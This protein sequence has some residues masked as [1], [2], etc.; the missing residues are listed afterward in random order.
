MSSTLKIATFNCEN[1]FKRPKVLNLRDYDKARGI[2]NEIE[3]LQALLCKRNYTPQDKRDISKKVKDLSPWLFVSQDRGKLFNRRGQV[4]ANGVGEWDGAITLKTESF[5]EMVRKN[6]AKVM[7][8]VEADIQCLIEVEDRSAV[9]RFSSEMLKKDGFQYNM[10]I[11]GNDQRGI[12]VGLYSR[13]PIGLIKTHIFDVGDDGRKIFS[14][15]CLEVEVR[16]PGDQPLYLLINHFKSKGWG[17]PE[18]S[19][20]KRR[21]QAKVVAKILGSYN[22]NKDYVVVAGDLNDTPESDP[23]HPLMAAKGLSDVLEMQFS[24][25]KDRWSYHYKKNEQ[26]DYL[27]ISDAMKSKL[28]EAGVFR[29]GMPDIEK[30]TVSGEKPLIPDMKPSDSASDHGAVWATFSI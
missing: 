8:A 16:L 18:A 14:R 10:V 5:S 17:K 3:A 4:V 30:N 15:D 24:D 1:L 11:D 13:R 23:L 25:Q 12:D 2:L 9:Q 21:D 6:T 22:L 7:K 26:I 19:D 27:L 20:A 29:R 28:K